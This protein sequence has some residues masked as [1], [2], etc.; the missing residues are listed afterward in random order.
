M[1]GKDKEEAGKQQKRC[2]GQPAGSAARRPYRPYSK[3]AKPT[4][5]LDI[6]LHSH[7]VHSLVNTKD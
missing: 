5:Y 4:N 1:K 3:P 6:F 7:R 2:R